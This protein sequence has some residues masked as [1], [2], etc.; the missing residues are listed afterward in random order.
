VARYGGLPGQRSG[1]R[2]NGSDFVIPVMHVMGFLMRVEV[3]IDG[4]R[5]HPGVYRGDRERRSPE[6]S[7][8]WFPRSAADGLTLASDTDL[9]GGLG[10]PGP[11]C[12]EAPLLPRF[13]LQASVIS[14]GAATGAR[15]AADGC[16]EEDR[17]GM[18]LHPVMQPEHA[19][20]GLRPAKT[21]TS[22]RR[23]QS[24][25]FVAHAPGVAA[26]AADPPR[27]F[28]FSGIPWG[29]FDRWRRFVRCVCAEAGRPPAVDARC[30]IRI[31]PGGR[32]T[33]RPCGGSS[34]PA[35]GSRLSA[36][37][38]AKSGSI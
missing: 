5:H 21:K 29:S 6:K 20:D 34:S 26:D 36:S 23:N 24:R 35:G 2:R 1:P 11:D 19:G 10:R 14:F 18:F 27:L 25:H 8:S 16:A 37:P 12:A 3:V 22:K 28:V 9:H 15:P 13:S 30:F 33:I 7:S 38:T 17:R 31:D 32:R 4:S